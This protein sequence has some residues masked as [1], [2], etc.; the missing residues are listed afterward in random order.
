M[1]IRDLIEQIAAAWPAYHQKGRVD[2]N[3][4]AYALVVKQFPEAIRPHIA[5]YDNII[6]EGST[7][8]G[9]ITAAP[10][11]A[12]FDR[13]FTTSATTGYCFGSA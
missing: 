11:I 2:K 12:L 1:T 6:L 7:G 10:W 5:G 9:N 3:D 13:R 4:P 8:A